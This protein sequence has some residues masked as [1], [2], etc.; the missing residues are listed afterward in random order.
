M[1][2]TAARVRVLIVDD[3]PLVVA[4]IREV[5]GE[6]ASIE[7]IGAAVTASEAIRTV[8]LER[9][10]VIFLDVRL[11]QD[12]G[13]S[14]ITEMR[15][16]WPLAECLVLAVSNDAESF[17]DALDR[18]VHGYL[19]DGASG[20][21]IRSAVQRV[22]AGKSHIDPAVSGYLVQTRRHRHDSAEPTLTSRE[23]DVLRLAAQGLTNDAIAESLKIK[24]ETVK[25]HLSRAFERLGARDRANA[26]AICMRRGLF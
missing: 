7:V 24:T 18:G 17:R 14:L 25:T 23:V 21:D 10:D 15:K 9:P 1:A 4:G 20:D 26:V 3:R 19:L 22:A 6:D 13:F 2:V 11:A 8:R 16:A 12:S 5:L